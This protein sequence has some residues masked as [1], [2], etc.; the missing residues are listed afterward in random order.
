MSLTEIPWLF[1]D[2]EN[3][4]FPEFFPTVEKMEGGSNK[5]IFVWL[6][7][8]ILNNFFPYVASLARAYF[9]HIIKWLPTYTE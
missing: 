5:Q 2:L 7:I 4:Y 6:S 1:P 8:S 3:I 9:C